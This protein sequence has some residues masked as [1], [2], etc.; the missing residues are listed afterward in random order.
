MKKYTV[1]YQSIIICSLLLL[2]S[3][4]EA[5][6]PAS[7]LQEMVTQ[8]QE[9]WT[10]ANYELK[11]D[12]QIFAFE[13]LIARVDQMKTNQPSQALSWLWSGIVKSSFAGAKGGL[14]ALSL[15]KEAKKDFEKSLQLDEKLLQGSAYASLGLLYHKVP[16]WPLAFGDDEIAEEMLKKSLAINPKGIDINYFYGEYLYDEREYKKAKHY[17]LAAQQAPLRDD[18][19]L[20][21]SYRQQE[22]KKLLF[23]T[24]KKIKK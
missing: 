1:I 8:L 21:D 13:K 4:A 12:E 11:D 5:K 10:T 2:N 22:I 24:L 6:I 15:A 19:Q 23:K 9:Q 14:G 20:A 3:L 17:L 16:G 7:G 18:W